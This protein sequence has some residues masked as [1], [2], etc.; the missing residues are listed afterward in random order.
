MKEDLQNYWM[1]SK[2][3]QDLWCFEVILEPILKGLYSSDSGFNA[4]VSY[5]YYNAVYE[6]VLTHEK[7]GR[8][9]AMYEISY[10][11]HMNSLQIDEICK[12]GNKGIDEVLY[13]SFEVGKIP[14]SS[15]KIRDIIYNWFSDCEENAF[16][17][18]LNP[19]R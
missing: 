1:L 6:H 13:G 5:E 15:S 18:N 8:S 2:D 14:G 3:H 16:P 7:T 11:E 19:N 9:L 12:E 17:E 10:P 4:F